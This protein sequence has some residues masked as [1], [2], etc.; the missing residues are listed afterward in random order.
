MSKKKKRV[1]GKK[2]TCPICGAEVFE[3]GLKPHIRLLHKLK[4]TEEVKVMY[5]LSGSELEKIGINTPETRQKLS[6][7]G[8]EK[9]IGAKNDTYKVAVN[10][11][12]GSARFE[13]FTS[14]ADAIR[15]AENELSKKKRN[16]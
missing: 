1:P 15:C 5:Q 3:R 9:R 11:G 2:T 8:I 10:I 4:I 16:T 7:L 13:Y 14:A 6:E 12:L